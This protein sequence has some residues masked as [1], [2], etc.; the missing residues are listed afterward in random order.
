MAVGFF[1]ANCVMLTK[2]P[3]TSTWH[4]NRDRKDGG[5]APFARGVGNGASPSRVLVF[6]AC[7][8]VGAG[9]WG[10]WLGWD[11]SY[12]TLPGDS[13][14]HGPYTPAQVVGCA[15]SVAVVTALLARWRDPF[16]VAGGVTFGFW[17]GWTAAAASDVDNGP[18]FWPIGSAL[19]LIGLVAGTA[20][21]AALGFASRGLRR[22]PAP[23]R[24][25]TPS[26]PSPATSETDRDAP[27][28]RWRTGTALVVVAGGWLAVG[29]VARLVNPLVWTYLQPVHVPLDLV[30]VV[31]V[32]WGVVLA[33]AAARRRRA[34]G[35]SIRPLARSAAGCAVL[36]AVVAVAR[37]VPVGDGFNGQA[38]VMAGPDGSPVVVLGLCR[39]E[40]DT[41]TV[42]DLDSDLAE[43]A[44]DRGEDVHV[45]QLTH[46]GGVE[47]VTSVDLTSPPGGWRGT[48]LRPPNP[49]EEE[50][51]LEAR[52]RGSVLD[53][54][55]FTRAE[56]EQL[57]PDTVLLSAWGE[58][59]ELVGNE[60]VPLED[61][62]AVACS[63]GRTRNG[64]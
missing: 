53:V 34:E 18:S 39:G 14:L 26:V 44:W 33:V 32:I 47:E 16:A 24:E 8:L 6:G 21:S 37:A 28:A 46:D 15:L 57:P 42:D 48:T 56:V 4:K 36:L 25:Q 3:T 60:Q 64:S 13:Q 43:Q 45:A 63:Q 62:A 51:Y 10:A 40:I 35:A 59:G 17:V 61:V 50:L 58:Q 49:G 2:H 30:A 52:G 12:Y 38:G 9:I 41:I 1:A 5:M 19:L 22:R 20:V 7:A 27:P 55:W 31:A 29:A 11:T 23:P 54:L